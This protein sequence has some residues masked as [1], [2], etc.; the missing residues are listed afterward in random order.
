MRKNAEQKRNEDVTLFQ[1]IMQT[2]HK[3]KQSK[4]EHRTP[5]VI[6]SYLRT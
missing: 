5:K 4:N 1:Y 6:V 3:I 2:Y